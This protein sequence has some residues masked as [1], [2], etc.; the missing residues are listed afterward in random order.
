[1]LVNHEAWLVALSVL[2][3]IQGAYV[4]LNLAL[5]LP[6]SAGGL[7]QLLLAGAALT[8]AVAIWSMH[9]V[10]ML[11]VRS[12]IPIDYHVLPTLVSFLVCVLVVGLAL[13]PIFA[14]S[15]WRRIHQ[16]VAKLCHWKA[17]SLCP[18]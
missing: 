10:G 11:A 8:L 2:V 6:G 15:V 5:E 7:R 4:G 14:W 18:A 12:P 17:R 16:A 1:M 13:E 9:F 3:A